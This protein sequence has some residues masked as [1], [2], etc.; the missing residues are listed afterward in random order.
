MVLES[1]AIKPDIHIRFHPA[2]VL[3]VDDIADNRNLLRECFADTQL[4]VSDANNGLEAVNAV[5]QG[6]ID[7]VLMDIRMPV[8]DG[9]Q[10]S[11]Q[12]KAFSTVPIIALTA[13]IMHDGYDRAKS[14]HFDGYL[15]KP[16]LKAE[17]ISELTRFLPFETVVETSVTEQ[18]LVLSKE[19]LRALPQVID[20]LEKQ[21]N[22]CE[23]ASKNN[24]LSEIKKFADAVLQ[25]GSEN[26]M[27]VVTDYAT[28]LHA[29][30]DGF[31][32]TAIKESLNVFPALL[33]QLQNYNR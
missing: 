18:A 31:D 22:P 21:A 11:E 10:A 17:L 16:V 4:N 33:A 12:I 24:N 9:Y 25:I 8:M 14:I 29:D 13:S 26:G 23:Q 1:E 32:I 6:N 3:V 28:T 2:N 15:R 5:K 7:L 19:E 27:A 20:A 30:I